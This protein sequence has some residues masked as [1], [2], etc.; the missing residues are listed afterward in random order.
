MRTSTLI[1][2]VALALCT[3]L[4][5]RQALG[6]TKPS[7]VTAKDWEPTDD[8][9][10]Q[11]V[12]DL[13]FFNATLF[14]DAVTVKRLEGY[15]PPIVG[16]EKAQDASRI[17]G[18]VFVAM[19]F[20]GLQFCTRSNDTNSLK[21]WQWP[22]ATALGHGQR[23]I[24]D[25]KGVDALEFYNLLVNGKV[26]ARFSDPYSRTAASHGFA[27]KEGRLKEV[28]YSGLSSFKAV[29]DG[30]LGQHHGL[31]LA[32]GGLGNPRWDPYLVGPGGT[33]L[34]P[35]NFYKPV[36]DLQQGHLYLHHA[37]HT[38][39]GALVESGVMVGL[40]SCAPGT[41]NM[42]GASHSIASASKDATKDRCV[43][44][45]QKMQKLLGSDGPAEIGGM[46]VRLD[47]G[48]VETLK[49]VL[50]QVDAMEDK[51]RAALFATLLGDAGPGATRDLR[52]ALRLE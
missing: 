41:K 46:W 19:A 51:S 21:D 36:K 50:A 1:P 15:T 47:K 49:R 10:L 28:K 20:G 23:V 33:A 27:W 40:E 30:F 17:L 43:D 26:L 38:E 48:K 52:A 8:R 42:Y 29:T 31:N 13:K 5:A 37:N 45:G 35:G 24:F 12:R 7:Q 6:P 14:P 39:G 22:L 9:A 34:D 32:F 16:I 4:P 18:R 25:L 44:G 3:A 2:A 11:F